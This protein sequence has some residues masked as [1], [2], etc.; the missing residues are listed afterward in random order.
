MVGIV[1]T[2]LLLAICTVLSSC[3]LWNNE[4]TP[5]EEQKF[6]DYDALGKTTSSNNPVK[7][8]FLGTSSLLISDNKSKILIDGFVSRPSLLSLL[9]G[10]N[11]DENRISTLISK[12]D[13][14]GNLDAVIPVHSHHDHVMDAFIIARNTGAE[15]VGTDSTFNVGKTEDIP[16]NLLKPALVNHT[17]LYGEFEVTLLRTE[18]AHIPSTF[19]RW[20]LGMN[21]EIDKPIQYPARLWD[22]KESQPFSI[23]INHKSGKMLVHASTSVSE[24]ALENVEADWVF[25]GI[26][27]LNK[28][29]T[30][31]QDRYF[32]ETVAAVGATR[33]VPIHWDDIFR[34]GDAEDLYPA[35]RFM[36]NFSAELLALERQIQ[37][38]EKPSAIKLMVKNETVYLD[39]IN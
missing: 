12:Y 17:Y 34:S 24:G 3:I 39:K 18:H 10:T 23:H 2:Y 7:V 6:K 21:K 38:Y 27:Q 28:L 22:Y 4:F 11:P 29:E 36:G 37:K 1:K 15:L 20:L 32:N 16:E 8:T 35:N 30:V 25:L 14:H 33:V 9:V 19:L 5:K 13:L 31:D 26:S